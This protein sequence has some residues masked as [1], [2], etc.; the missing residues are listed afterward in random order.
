MHFVR[1]V[2]PTNLCGQS[3][4][5]MILDT[6][7][8]HAIMKVGKKGLTRTKDLVVALRGAGCKCSGKLKRGW[9]PK[10][11]G[12]YLCKVRW[13]DCGNRG[14][15]VVATLGENSGA[16]YYDPELVGP[17]SIMLFG[18]ISSHMKVETRGGR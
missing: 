11:S 4:V 7:L 15:W 18:Y 13:S 5:A 16:T 1:Q 3:C 12:T 17:T 10:E 8:H 14:H 2:E 9:P 6:T